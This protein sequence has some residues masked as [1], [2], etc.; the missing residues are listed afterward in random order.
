MANMLPLLESSPT[1][2]ALGTLE[3][4]EPSE[5]QAF[6]HGH[7][8]GLCSS[9]L[10]PTPPPFSKI[11]GLGLNYTT[12]FNCSSFLLLQLQTQG[13]LVSMIMSQFYNKSLIYI[14]IYILLVLFSGEP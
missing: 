7:R 6:G 1:S 2:P 14:Y 3:H 8:L 11:F 9:H 13:L 4:Y 5:S 12:N 10:T